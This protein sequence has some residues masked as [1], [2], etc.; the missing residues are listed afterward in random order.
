[1]SRPIDYAASQPGLEL[2][3]STDPEVVSPPSQKYLV[4]ESGPL[5]TPSKTD[6]ASYSPQPAYAAY[7]SKEV[8]SEPPP[9][10][11]IGHK[12]K[13]YFLIGGLVILGIIIGAVVGGV[14]G[15]KAA[16][17]DGPDASAESASSNSS[18][19]NPTV[20]TTAV[21][22]KTRLTVTGRRVQGNGFTSRLFWQG[23]DNKIRTSRYTSSTGQWSSPI[24]F[25]DVDAK[26]GTPIAATIYL[27]FPQFEFFY[28]DPS[29]TFQGVNFFED[30]TVPKID[31]I[32]SERTP[33]TVWDSSKMSAYWPY[34]VYQNKNTTFHRVVYDG[35][36]AGWFNDTLQGWENPDDMPMGDVG[37][38]IAV[39]PL[40]IDF[41]TP[42]TAGLAYRDPNGR[43]SIFPFGGVDTGVAW[44]F[45]SPDVTIPSGTSIA[46]I[47]IGREGTNTT[48]TWILYQDE[49]NKIQS[50]WQ[51]DDNSW[52]GPQEV[53]DADAGTDIACLTEQVGDQPTQSSLASQTD[54]RRCYYQYKGLIREKRLTSSSW[55]DGASIP[56]E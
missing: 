39:I 37:S 30:E 48:N 33:F 3:Y 34:V 9:Q 53:G 38:G 4:L 40:A 24:V 18:S 6:S 16:S 17:S 49:S 31:S 19:P 45:G 2:A 46:A 35:H 41:Q 11:G 47:A 42:Y 5:L 22:P 20:N 10:R 21:R 36:G 7:G 32:S 43:L 1:M 50:V 51:E 13:L 56:I 55:V 15:S 52:H 12:R 25:H 23:G 26:P 14:L 28:L 54:M 44:N 8:V 29:S 27:Q